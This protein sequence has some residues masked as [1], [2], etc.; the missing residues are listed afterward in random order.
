MKEV[1]YI[2]VYVLVFFPILGMLRH[3]E[4]Y[5]WRRHSPQ[6]LTLGESSHEQLARP[7]GSGQSGKR[8]NEADWFG[9]GAIAVGGPLNFQSNYHINIILRE[10]VLDKK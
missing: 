7:R 1:V 5:P 8:Q 4:A 3:T 6:G 10:Y 2:Y 9:L